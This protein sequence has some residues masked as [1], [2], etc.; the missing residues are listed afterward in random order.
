MRITATYQY[1]A[2]MYI[3]ACARRA[4]CKCRLTSFSYA[5]LYLAHVHVVGR[6]RCP[7]EFGPSRQWSRGTNSLADMVRRNLFA[8]VG[9]PAG[10]FTHARKRSG[11]RKQ[12]ETC[13][14]QIEAT[15][16]SKKT[17]VI[18]DEVFRFLSDNNERYVENCTEIRK[19]L[20]RRFSE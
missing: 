2:A 15:K 17:A 8:S 11:P 3:D 20:I 19:R 14:C 7:S 6:C 13:W 16:M 1:Y 12:S 10:P 9:S 18:Y 5:K 4:L